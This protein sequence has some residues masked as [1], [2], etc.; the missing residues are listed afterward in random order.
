MVPDELVRRFEACT[1][2]PEEF[3]HEQHVYVAW[4]YLRQMPL[5]DAA[6]R[7]IENLKRFAASLGK[8]NLYHETITWAF[9]LLTNERVHR[10]PGADWAAFR[11]ANPDL[12]TWKPSVLD[13]YYR[14]ETLGSDLAR[15]AFLFPDRNYEALR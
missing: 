13:R 4:C 15:A 1:L 6:K 14:P 8:A 7:F 10:D 9:L 3:R 5:T 11:E 2:P 12:F